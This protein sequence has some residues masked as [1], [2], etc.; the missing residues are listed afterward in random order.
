MAGAP[1]LK[2][3]T[4]E[5][6]QIA[7]IINGILDAAAKSRRGFTPEV[8]AQF[9]DE[10]QAARQ[11]QIANA[12]PTK[13]ISRIVAR[14][15][16]PKEKMR[17]DINVKVGPRAIEDSVNL[18]EMLELAAVRGKKLNLKEWIAG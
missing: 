10:G 6:D 3:K 14:K 4:T 8:I 5:L 18:A 15:N 1:E 16:E 2:K 7:Q 17:A 13:Q 11:N 9:Y 12:T